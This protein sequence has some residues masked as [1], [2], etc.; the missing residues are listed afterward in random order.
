[1]VSQ[2][3]VRI[4]TAAGRWVL[5]ATIGGS[6]LA[7]LDSTVVNV[8]LARIG[9]DLHVGFTGLQW[10]TNAYTLTLAA[11]ILIGGVLGD[12]FGRR[13]IFVIGA[14]WF[15]LASAACALAP[16]TAVLVAAR[17]VQGVGAALLTPGSL[18]IISVS[19]AGKDRAEAIGIWSG[20]GG[21]A[22]ALG[23]FL[24]GWL[25]DLNWRLIFL[26]NVP[27]AAVVVLIAVTKVPE[28]R[29]R[30][31]GGRLDLPGAACGVVA[32][33]GITY[34]LTEAGRGGGT[35]AIVAGVIGVAAAIAFVLIER[36]TV[37]PLVRLD[38]FADRVFAATNL[39][40]VFVYAALAVYF[41]LL[42]LQLQVVVGWSP[43]AAGTSLLPI[44]AVMLLLSARFGALSE[45][46][47]PRPLMTGGALVAAGGLALATRIGPGAS[48]LLDVL[49]SVLVLGLGL[50]CTVAPLTAAV[51]GAV[52][53]TLAGAASGINNA[54]ARSAGLLAVAVIPVLAGLSGQAGVDPGVFDSG[55]STSMWIGAGLLAAAAAVSWFGIAPITGPPLRAGE[56]V[57][58]HRQSSCSV[59]APPLHPRPVDT[60]A[61]G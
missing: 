57:P 44:T 49:P 53:Q 19:F 59:C 8:A 54:I 10:I 48:Y 31:S 37:E 52:P 12:Q 60:S 21:V 18:A 3:S 58:V 41:F 4:G 9:A 47:G 34:A 29:G 45:R 28:T 13:R 51:L 5:A 14:V 33:T 22:G 61:H 40:T 43:L 15:A 50:S 2:L 36:R 17:A 56:V 55:F 39:A 7:L 35:G 20:L 6:S 24:G 32:L 11:F 26:V 30:R 42:A 46:T 38:L 23:P 1:V 16:S 25:V 27:V